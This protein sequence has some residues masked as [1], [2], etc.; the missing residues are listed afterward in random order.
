MW[1]IV[2]L[3]TWYVVSCIRK[4]SGLKHL[5]R[6]FALDFTFGEGNGNSL[7][8]SCLEN[9]VDGG[10]WWATVHGVT[11]SR[12]HISDQACTRE[13]MS[14][15]NL[16]AM[17]KVEERDIAQSCLTLFDPVDWSPPGS[18]IHGILQAR[19]Q[20]WAAISFSRG[21]QGPR[22]RTRVSRIAGRRFNLWITGE[23]PKVE[24]WC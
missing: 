18:S 8:Y 14:S 21:S 17:V 19:T 12:T 5:R 24:A 15:P 16:R 11:K 20:A 3:F 23:A 9:P 22:D 4:T 2:L 6:I 13:H 10:A 7:H 1:W